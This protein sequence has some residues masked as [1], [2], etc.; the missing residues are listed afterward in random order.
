MNSV[1]SADPVSTLVTHLRL[2]TP[3]ETTAC[4]W[5]VKTMMA[6]A[7]APG[8]LSAE[9][10][11]SDKGDQDEWTLLQRFRSRA[12]SDAW[13][14]APE[15]QSII[16]DMR[17]RHGG[18]AVQLAHEQLGQFGSH[19]NVTTAI[20]TEVQPGQE[21]SYFDLECRLQAA[22]AKFPGYQG[23]FIQPPTAATP[24]HW[25][26]LLRFYTPETL[27]HWFSSPERKRLLD[28]GRSLVKSLDIKQ[29]TGS[30]PGWIPLDEHGQSPPNWKAFLLVL[31]GLYPIVMCE[32]AFLN[33]QLSSVPPALANLIGNSLSVAATTWLTMPC[34]IKWFGKWL[35]LRKTA[36]WQEHAKGT[37][38]IVAI[39]ITEVATL[40][41]LLGPHKQ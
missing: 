41:N 11:P 14:A 35:F 9:I 12:Q 21:K 37:L 15:H 31:L 2:Q 29:I 26:T 27:D 3:A 24:G 34:F 1:A 19:G 38:L 13:L 4:Q 18:D 8:F 6:G 25:V 36:S 32:I 22:Q 39:F 10:M 40:W 20:A 17:A 5:L 23:A 28:E 7:S 33:P 16:A 30:F